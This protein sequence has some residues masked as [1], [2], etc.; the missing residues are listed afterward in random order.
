MFQHKK[1]SDLKLSDVEQII[2]LKFVC[3]NSKIVVIN[4]SKLTVYNLTEKLKMTH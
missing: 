1:L 2:D 3:N 4:P